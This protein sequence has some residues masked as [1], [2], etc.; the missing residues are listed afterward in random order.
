MLSNHPIEVGFMELL[1]FLIMGLGL[2]VLSTIKFPF[3]LG[4]VM[5]LLSRQFVDAWLMQAGSMFT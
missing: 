1:V 2:M 4:S 5:F 3:S